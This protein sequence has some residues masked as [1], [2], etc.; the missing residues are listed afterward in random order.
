MS[1]YSRDAAQRL[2]AKELLIAF[3]T[4]E[5]DSAEQKIVRGEMLCR[6]EASEEPAEPDYSPVHDE[7]VLY[8]QKE[9][10][11]ILVSCA[12]DYERTLQDANDFQ[13][14]LMSGATTK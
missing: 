14:S 8:T 3:E 13:K 4:S 5:K 9:F 6:L 12:R 1:V 7:S 11:Q 2:T 10:R